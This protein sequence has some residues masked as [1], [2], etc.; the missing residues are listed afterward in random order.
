MWR[1]DPPGACRDA[2]SR[3]GP[4]LGAARGM[5]RSAACGVVDGTHLGEHAARLV[6]H[7]VRR[8]P[9]Q[10]LALGGQGRVAR[11]VGPSRLRRLVL[12]A[13]D[14]DD[15]HPAVG[16]VDLEVVAPGPERT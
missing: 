1:A 6:P 4:R 12:R 3:E 14:L 11:G 15:E 2:T 16:Q 7:G 13:V 8:D 5:A 9:Q 10:Q